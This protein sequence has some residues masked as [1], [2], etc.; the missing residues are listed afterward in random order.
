MLI[1]RVNYLRVV[2]YQYDAA[3]SE[4]MKATGMSTEVAREA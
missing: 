1:P 2:D 3:K 4:K